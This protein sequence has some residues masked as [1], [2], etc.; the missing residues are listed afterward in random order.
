LEQLR[1]TTHL[2]IL[3]DFTN[4]T[5]ER[6][7]ADEELRRLLVTTNFA[8]SDGSGPEAMGLLYTTSGVLTKCGQPKRTG[9]AMKN[10]R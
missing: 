7:F 9:G 2:E 5:L 1:S 8:E 6:Q 10:S 3:S 4:E